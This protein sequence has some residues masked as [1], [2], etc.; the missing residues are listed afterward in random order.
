MQLHTREQL[1]RILKNVESIFEELEFVDVEIKEIEDVKVGQLREIFVGYPIYGMVVR[2]LW[3]GIYWIVPFTID[4]EF[5][6]KTALFIALDE[7]LTLLAGFPFWVHVS[8][9]F[10]KKFSMVV[11]EFS[12]E[13]TQKVLKWVEGFQLKELDELQERYVRMLMRFFAGINTVTILGE[14]EKLE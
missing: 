11:E 9:E 8:G 6:H 13:E 12:K 10:L 2:R 14:L 3:E 5:A 7:K 4:V 1:E